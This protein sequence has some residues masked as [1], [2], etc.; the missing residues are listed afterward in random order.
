MASTHSRLIAIVGPTASGKSEIALALAE[1]LGASILSADSMQVYR[2]MDIGTAKPTRAERARVPHYLIDVADPRDPFSVSDFR[3]KAVAVVE[4]HAE[5]S[6]PLIVCG[7]TGLYFK[8]LFEGLA[9]G[10]PPNES[11]RAEMESIATEKGSAFLHG[12]LAQVDPLSAETIH[13]NDRKRI[14][15]ALEIHRGTGATKKELEEVQERP[16]FRDRVEWF[17][18]LPPWAKLDERIEARV[19]RMFEAGLVEEV[20]GLTERGCSLEHTSMQAL[21]YKETLAYLSGRSGLEET[22][23]TIKQRTRRFAR[24]QMTWFRTLSEV[25][26]RDPSDDFERPGS[27]PNWILDR[28]CY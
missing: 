4:D 7:G 9:Q 18:L 1:R 23:E 2:G 3:E 10:P 12:K 16:P 24:R 19:E 22:K 26:W 11:Y 25:A 5:R 20:K 8:A 13:P 27:L 15:R 21:G 6:V 28:L 14:I 17:G